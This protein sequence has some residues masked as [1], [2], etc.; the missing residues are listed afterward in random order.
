M[1]YF[2]TKIMTYST[3]NPLSQA[4]NRLFSALERLEYNLQHVTVSHERDL[5]QHQQLQHFQR[6]NSSLRQ[7]QEKMQATIAGL[8]K[9]YEELQGVAATI[10]GKLDTSIERLT[11]ILE[12]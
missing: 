4:V 11:H 10:Y 3:E 8:Q 5:Q 2:S 6:E 12:K 1:A 7:E 9:Q